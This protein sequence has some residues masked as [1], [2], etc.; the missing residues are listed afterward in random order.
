MGN[1]WEQATG[2]VEQGANELAGVLSGNP[3]DVL[4][5]QT[6][7]EEAVQVAQGASEIAAGVA[8][9]AGSGGAAS[10]AAF[11][12]LASGSRQVLTGAMNELASQTNKYLWAAYTLAYAQ[13]GAL[14][15]SVSSP[16]SWYRVTHK[17]CGG[18]RSTLGSSQDN[19]GKAIG[20]YL[21][22]PQIRDANNLSESALASFFGTLKAQG[23]DG[24]QPVRAAILSGFRESS[25]SANKGAPTKV[26]PVKPIKPGAPAAPGA[27]ADDDTKKAGWLAAA[28]A[29]FFFLR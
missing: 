19:M 16:G 14:L 25:G 11:P 18:G 23:M 29:A 22:S 24:L 28:A 8:A 3:S 1:L 12:G 9:I 5:F 15:A 13:Q 20:M 7:T 4:A 10:A 2:A 21:G 6:C 17:G 27:P 26:L